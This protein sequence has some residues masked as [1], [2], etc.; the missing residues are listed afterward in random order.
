MGGEVLGVRVRMP[1]WGAGTEEGAEISQGE[2]VGN[3]QRLSAASARV[4][5]R[6][7]RGGTAGAAISH[8]EGGGVLGVQSARC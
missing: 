4:R 6:G 8:G 5:T 3:A 7:C 2:W 1:A